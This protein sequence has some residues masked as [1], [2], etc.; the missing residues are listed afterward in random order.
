MVDGTFSQGAKMGKREPRDFYMH[1]MFRNSP[2]SWGAYIQ[3]LHCL[4]LSFTLLCSLSCV[5]ARC[6]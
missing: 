6:P 3:G 2:K 1:A 5:N 4:L